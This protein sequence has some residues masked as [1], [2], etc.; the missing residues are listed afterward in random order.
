MTDASAF[1]MLE[2]RK[3]EAQCLNAQQRRWNAQTSPG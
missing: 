2:L 1:V 3:F